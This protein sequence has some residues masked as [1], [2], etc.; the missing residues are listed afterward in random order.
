MTEKQK[1]MYIMTKDRGKRNIEQD[2][3][4]TLFPD[5]IINIPSP[6]I[7][8]L[9]VCV[10][11]TVLTHCLGHNVLDL[12]VSEVECSFSRIVRIIGCCHE[13]RQCLSPH[14]C[15]Q[16]W[17]Q[18]IIMHTL[19]QSTW[20]RKHSSVCS[21]AKWFFIFSGR[22]VKLTTHL[23]FLPTQRMNTVSQTSNLHVFMAHKGTTLLLLLAFTWKATKTCCQHSQW[24]SKIKN[25]SKKVE[26]YHYTDKFGPTIF[27][28]S[29]QVSRNYSAADIRPFL[30]QC[31]CGFLSTKISDFFHLYKY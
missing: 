3:M 9:Q 20:V 15:V 31:E 12:K 16:H 6:S 1:L 4:S 14:M 30:K 7:P 18:M 17:R 22:S 29:T 28:T 19:F 10:A 5:F 27:N 21:R 25:V 2:S 11:C 26:Y 24:Q 13:R 23:C 8:Q